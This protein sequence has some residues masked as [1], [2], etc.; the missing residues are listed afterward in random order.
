MLSKILFS[1]LLI[2]DFFVVFTCNAQNQGESFIRAEKFPANWLGIWKG[3]L[4]IHK[5]SEPDKKINMEL[6]ILPTDSAKN[7]WKWKIIYKGDKR[8]DIRNYYLM[9]I[10][11]AKGIF[12]LDEKNTIL[13]DFRYH[14][15]SFYSV[16]AVEN[17]ILFSSYEL[18]GSYLLFNIT[19][20]NKKN[21]RKSGQGQKE[22]ITEVESYPV[23]VIQQAILNKQ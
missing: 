21:V 22:G 18:K 5:A 20:C 3:E 13:I 10:D 9:A 16:F 1:T 15:N 4:I 6:H 8:D 14:E 17:S 2:F 19:V 7:L 12:V 11:T 23:T